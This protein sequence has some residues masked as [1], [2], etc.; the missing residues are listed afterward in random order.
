MEKRALCM[1]H[2]PFEGP[3]AFAP[4]LAKRGYALE[5]RLVPAEG[6]PAEPGDFLLVMGGPMSVNDPEAWIRE[7]I[8]FIKLAVQAGRPVLGVCLGAQLLA[9]ALGAKVRPGPGVE[10]GMTP[11]RLTEEGRRDPAFGALPPAVEVFQWHGEGFDL[12][13]G[14]VSLAASDLFPYQAFRFGARAYGLLFHLEMERAG[15]EAL[16]RECPGD[17]RRAKTDA[18]SLLA[19]AEPHLPRQHEWADRLI[20]QM[21]RIGEG[22]WSAASRS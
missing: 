3:G 6:L 19:R 10:I 2:V 18:G 8:E 12:P 20:E 1:Q 16:C 9:R 7:E 22:Y 5:T 15:I 21:G 4:L 17:L 11:V 13:A 14:A